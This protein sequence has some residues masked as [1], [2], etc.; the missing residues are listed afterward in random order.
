MKSS[1]EKE[2]I[3]NSIRTN[4]PELSSEDALLLDDFLDHFSSI[5]HRILSRE[6]GSD[7]SRLTSDSRSDIQLTEKAEKID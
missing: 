6:D 3:F 2:R 1:I 7:L 4:H 5:V